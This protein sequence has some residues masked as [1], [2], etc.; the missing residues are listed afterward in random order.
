MRLES[1]TP[2]TININNIN[3]VNIYLHSTRL[4]KISF[5]ILNNF[6]QIWLAYP[7]QDFF[8]SIPSLMPFLTIVSDVIHS[9]SQSP[10]NEGESNRIIS[11]NIGQYLTII[12]I[13]P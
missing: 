1:E 3:K 13:A 9:N 12:S 4:R 5:I 11:E 7:V 6:T 2:D 8:S 10:H